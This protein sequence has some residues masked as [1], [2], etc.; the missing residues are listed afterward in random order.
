M[1]ELK[2]PTVEK[3]WLDSYKVGDRVYLFRRT[4][5]TGEQVEVLT[6]EIVRATGTRIEVGI[7]R[8]GSDGNPEVSS[9]VYVIRRGKGRSQYRE[10]DGEGREVSTMSSAMTCYPITPAFTAYFTQEVARTK[11]HRLSREL[12]HKISKLTTSQLMEV[13]VEKLQAFLD[14]VE[15]ANDS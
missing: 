10:Y 13:G 1:D 9:F 6:G 7:V 14:D 8:P 15:R 11:A 3:G 2:M 5:W 12:A 4:G